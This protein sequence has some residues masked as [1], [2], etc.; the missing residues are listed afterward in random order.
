MS[1]LRKDT[2]TPRSWLAF[3][4]VTRLR[5]LPSITVFVFALTITKVLKVLNEIGPEKKY[6]QVFSV[7]CLSNFW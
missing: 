1:C 6:F 3:L 5:F 2:E 4:R 7:P